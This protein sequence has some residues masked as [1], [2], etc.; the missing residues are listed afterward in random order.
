MPADDF[1]HGRL[2]LCDLRVRGAGI[3][4]VIALGLFP[5]DVRIAGPRA[6]EQTDHRSV[7]DMLRRVH[8][9]VLLLVVGIE[10]GL[11][12]KSVNQALI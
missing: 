11:F 9:R 7:Q 12:H 3:Q 5:F 6:A 10:N 2:N 4:Q 1:V 8:G